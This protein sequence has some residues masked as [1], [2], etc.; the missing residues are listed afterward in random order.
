MNEDVAYPKGAV[1]IK[2]SVY[3]VI[4][5]QFDEDNY[6]LVYEEFIPSN[7][8]GTTVDEH[9]IAYTGYNLEGTN[10]PRE[11][12][13]SKFWSTEMNGIESLIYITKDDDTVYTFSDYKLPYMI[14]QHMEVCKN[15]GN[16]A[17]ILDF[18]RL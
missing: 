11:E 8:L 9:W 2:T 7:M 4:I 17:D 18:I 6:Y 13:I 14:Q 12:L 10:I 16:M 5:N 15:L 1:V 3:P